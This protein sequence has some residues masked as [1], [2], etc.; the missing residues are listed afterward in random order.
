MR[1]V[2]IGGGAIGLSCAYSLDRDGADV[3]VLERDRV[4]LGA[5][6]GGTRAG[7]VRCSRRRSRRRA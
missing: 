2:V 1:V 7:S 6:P 4:G 5:S 3:V